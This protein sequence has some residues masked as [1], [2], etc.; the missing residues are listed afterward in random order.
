MGMFKYYS[1]DEKW[2]EQGE[3]SKNFFASD[4]QKIKIKMSISRHACKRDNGGRVVV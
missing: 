2:E 4:L 3:S 1:C